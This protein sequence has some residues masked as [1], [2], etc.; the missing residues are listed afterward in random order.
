[1]SVRRNRPSKLSPARE[2]STRTPSGFSTRK[3]DELRKIKT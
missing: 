3:Q 1:M 2:F